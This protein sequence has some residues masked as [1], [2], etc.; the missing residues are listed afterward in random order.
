MLGAAAQDLGW[1]PA[2]KMS[3]P[4]PLLP[5]FFPVEILSGVIRS[6]KKDGEWKVG[7]KAECLDTQRE[8]FT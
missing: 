6:V 3:V 2:Q 1:G 5:F 7:A 4:S 8:S